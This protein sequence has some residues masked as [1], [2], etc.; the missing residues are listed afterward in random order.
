[1][2]ERTRSRLRNSIFRFRQIVERNYL[3]LREAFD[4]GR[5]AGCFREID[6]AHV[7]F[8]AW[9]MRPNEIMD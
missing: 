6:R 4:S 1:M 9:Y 2:S 5:I 8:N 3:R 7:L